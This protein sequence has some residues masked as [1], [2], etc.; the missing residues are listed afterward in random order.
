MHM[1]EKG[2]MK[3]APKTILPGLINSTT[4]QYRQ[5]SSYRSPF[6]PISVTA[7]ARYLQHL[8][9]ALFG[10]I[11]R[12]YRSKFVAH[13]IKKALTIPLLQFARL[14][15]I[16]RRASRAHRSNARS[17]V[18][19]SFSV[20]STR[21]FSLKTTRAVA[22]SS[23][24]TATSTCRASPSACF[25]TAFIEIAQ[26]L[27]INEFSVAS[28]LGKEVPDDRPCEVHARYHRIRSWA[29]SKVS[30]SSDPREL[31][32]AIAR[33]RRDCFFQTQAMHAELMLWPMEL[34]PDYHLAQ[35]CPIRQSGAR[36]SNSGR[37]RS[38]HFQ[39][40]R[41]HVT[42]IRPATF[43]VILP[44]GHLLIAPSK[45]LVAL[46]EKLNQSAHAALLDLV[47]ELLPVCLD[48]PD[49]E[50]VQVIYAPALRRAI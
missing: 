24:N 40:H 23:I 11:G 34:H 25:L 3:C 27:C 39:P 46:S 41:R 22:I 29:R 9:T 45:L 28:L 19:G 37:R 38:G 8:M 15:S 44:N 2:Q 12:F 4:W 31:P 21:R 10:K 16:S 47:A 30:F 33:V 50:H 48:Q 43:I 13:Y 42:N 20:D 6:V 26:P 5:Y 7:S 36:T 18:M 14:P 49:A 17:I 35:A 1:I 32:C